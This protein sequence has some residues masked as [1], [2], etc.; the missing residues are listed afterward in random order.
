[1]HVDCPVGR[2]TQRQNKETTM[3]DL[4][5]A[6]ELAFTVSCFGSPVRASDFEGT[7]SGITE[8]S[9]ICVAAVLEAR[10]LYGALIGP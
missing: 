9:L 10:D 8:N 1:M 2:R 4:P 5:K 7:V 6:A 3:L